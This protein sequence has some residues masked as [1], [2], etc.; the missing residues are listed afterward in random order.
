[1]RRRA[2]VSVPRLLL[3]WRRRVSQLGAV[4]LGAGLGATDLGTELSAMIHCAE[5]GAKVYGAELGNT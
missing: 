4:D 5:L 1:M 2:L 3:P